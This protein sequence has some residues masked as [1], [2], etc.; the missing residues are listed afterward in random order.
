MSELLAQIIPLAQKDNVDSWMNILFVVVLAV[1]WI[2]GGII[3]ANK[4]KR[5]GRQEEQTPLKPAHKPPARSKGLLEQIFE[6]ARAHVESAQ[7]RPSRPSPQQPST[8]LAAIRSAAQK[9]AA[10]VEQAAQL[11]TTKPT[12]EPE[13]PPPEPHIQP[14]I[15]DLPEY[16]DKAVKKLQAKHVSVPA[17]IT[18]S[19]HLSEIL[20]DYSDPDELRRAIL[21]YEILGRPLSLR[22][23]SGNIIG[24]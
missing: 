7:D 19:R 2:V 10:Q 18:E 13:L 16:T 12:P 5:E 1:F 4:N 14:D 6:Q 24:F 23:P 15:R 8:K 17:E 21:H 3:K 20:S 11:K 22:D 9:Y